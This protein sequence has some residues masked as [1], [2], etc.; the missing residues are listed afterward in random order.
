MKYIDI[1]YHFIREVKFHRLIHLNY[2]FTSNIIVNKLTK[3]LL[4]LKFTHFTN[5]MSFISQ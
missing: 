1:H 2:I 4:T 3:L 5:L